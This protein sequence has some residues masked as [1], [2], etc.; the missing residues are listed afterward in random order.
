MLRD[1]AQRG[2]DGTPCV[3]SRAARLLSMRAGEGDA[4]ADGFVVPSLTRLG[5]DDDLEEEPTCGCRKR[6]VTRAPLFPAC[7]LQ[8]AVQPQRVA[9]RRD[10]KS[11]QRI[12][13]TLRP[14]RV[15]WDDDVG[16]SEEATC[17][18]RKPS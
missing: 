2:R 11:G 8:G 6:C 4:V 14:G 3:R 15:D 7:Y 18:C 12:A 9:R 10:S 5:Y 16:A 17:E 1:A 13:A